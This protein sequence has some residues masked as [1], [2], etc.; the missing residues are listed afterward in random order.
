MLP[1][2][3]GFLIK[4]NESMTKSTTK[5]A[6][7]DVN[8]DFFKLIEENDVQYIDFRFTDTKGKLQ[9]TAQH[10]C[11]ID[12]EFLNEGVMFDGS[13]IAGWKG[14]DESD[15]ALKP[16]LSTAI[17]DP[18]AAQPTITVF[19]DVNE[20]LTGLSYDRDPRSIANAAENYM[21][22]TGIADT[23]FFGPEAEFFI[24]DD[25]RIQTDSHKMS[26]EI[27]SEE[28][29]NNSNTKYEAGNM[30]H[31]PGVKGG[32]FPVQPMDST[33]DLRAEMVTILD[34]MGVTMEKHHHEVAPAQCELG[35]KF[36]TLADC[37]DKMQLYKYVVHNTAHAYGKTAT[38]M[39]KPV[40]GD[41]GSQWL[42]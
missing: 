10:I 4:E 24:F 17:M 8:A 21:K 22:S 40:F 16:D 38:F 37:A 25:V 6:S 14:I 31:R 42:C 27:D 33:S 18:F 5:A 36:S 28:A 9:H 34:D 30:G 2:V 11:T 23:C 39:P 1:S 20:P 32:Y 3:T 29:P 35:M 15:M 41:N 12:E 13:S 19:C 26:Y 7:N